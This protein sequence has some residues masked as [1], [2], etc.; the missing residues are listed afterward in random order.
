MINPLK[1]TDEVRDAYLRY[2]LTTFEVSNLELRQAFQ[3]ELHTNSGYTKGPYLEATPPFRKGRSL[4]QLVIGGQFSRAWLD[5]PSI[6]LDRSLYAHQDRAIDKILHGRNIIV[7]T[8]TGSGKTEA[9]LYPIVDALMREHEAGTLTP[10]VRALL[11][12][13]MNALVNDQLKR[14]R[15]LLCEMSYISFGRF[16]GETK[17]T[18][19]EALAEYPTPPPPG[20]RISREA[21]RRDP[22]HILITNYAMLEYLLQRPADTP[23]FD[24]KHAGHWRFLVLDEVHTYNG[25]SGAEVGMLVRR[26]KDRLGIAHL[27]AIGTSATMGSGEKDFPKV[28]EFATQLFSEP[29]DWIQEDKDQQDVVGADRLSLSE[30]PT[31]WGRLR[32]KAYELLLE[33]ATSGTEPTHYDLSGMGIPQK[34]LDVLER[35]WERGGGQRWVYDLLRGDENIRELSAALTTSKPLLELIELF[36]RTRDFDANGFLAMVNLAV[37]AKPSEQDQSLIP[38]RYHLFVRATE[39]VFVGLY[40]KSKIFLTRHE[41]RRVGSA[42]YPVFELGYCRRCGGTY[43]VGTID[44]AHKLKPYA[45]YR[46]Q[47]DIQIQQSPDY[48]GLT[49]GDEEGVDDDTEGE[50]P[51]H[52]ESLQLCQRCGWIGLTTVVPPSNC[53]A[54]DVHDLIPVYKSPVSP[55]G[56]HRCIHCGAGKGRGPSRFIT[57]QDA[58]AAV[59]ATAVYSSL[60]PESP[61]A[62]IRAED[63]GKL[64]IFSD[65]RQ[66]AAFFAPYLETSYQRIV[67]RR[68]IWEA[69]TQEDSLALGNP[70]LADVHDRLITLSDKYGMMA[71]QSGLSPAQKSAQ[72]WEV[73]LR[74]LVSGSDI[75]LEGVGMVAIEPIIDAKWSPPELAHWSDTDRVWDLLT[76]LWNDFRAHGAFTLPNQV[77]PASILPYEALDMPGFSRSTRSS[78]SMPWLPKE[79]YRNGRLDYLAR[80]GVKLGWPSDVAG[81]WAADLLNDAFTFFTDAS[82]P[83]AQNNCFGAAG[84]NGVVFKAK[85]ERWTIR[86]LGLHE[87]FRCNACGRIFVRNIHGVCPA[88]KC[89]GILEHADSNRLEENHYYQLYS[90]INPIPMKSREHTAQINNFDAQRL[91]EQFARGEVSV[92][93]CSTTFEL[94]V[95][96][97]ELEAVFMRNVPPE[98]ANYVQRAGRAGRRTSTAAIA[99]TFA[100]RRSHDIAQFNSPERYVNGHVAP[101]RVVLSNEKIARRHLH[102]I[103]TSWYFR[104]HPETYGSMQKFLNGDGEDWD[105]NLKQLRMELNPVPLDLEGSISRVIPQEL[106]EELEVSTNGWVEQFVGPKGV[107]TQ[108]VEVLHETIAEIRDLQDRRYH[109]GRRVDAYGKIIKTL[110]AEPSLSFFPSHNVL[111]KYGFPVDVVPLRIIHGSEEASRLEL[112]RDLGLAIW[113]YAPGNSVVAGGLLWKSRALVQRP[114]MTWKTHQ[115]AICRE[116]GYFA[117]SKT[118]L[119]LDSE[120]CEGCG[121]QLTKKANM[122]IPQ[123]GFTT[124]IGD[125]PAPPGSQ[126]P[127]RV[128]GRRV[129]FSAFGEHGSPERERQ[130]LR[131]GTGIEWAYSKSG[132]FTVIN[133]G[134]FGRGY[135]ICNLCGWAEPWRGMEKVSERPTHDKPF[136]IPCPGT[137]FYRASLGHQFFTDVVLLTFPNLRENDVSFWHSLLYGL[138]EGAI[139]GLSITRRDVGATL[140]WTGSK[141]N[142]T[143]VFYDDVPGGAGHVKHMTRN[144]E[145]VFD[146]ALSRVSGS[147]GCGPETS[148]YGCL[149]SYDNQLFHDSLVRGRAETFLKQLSAS[150]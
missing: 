134:Q 90:T 99:V 135:R 130:L 98:P 93:S 139:G 112:T 80:L 24:G 16:T 122:L 44:D 100:Q 26:L 127:E 78:R 62:H 96:A 59:V 56:Y 40:P 60:Q 51:T 124:S 22:P 92:L 94:G 84:K 2:L 132:R 85:Y 129:F 136:G 76:V 91:Q 145:R 148:C 67:W 97:G 64:L 104:R 57:G 1:L 32:P 47:D 131:D 121:G 21:L 107:L 69:L 101:P 125:K 68:L 12:Y 108:S 109:E 9:F 55:Q 52:L 30:F 103:V 6:P 45:P 133:H 43:I 114:G 72:V 3:E 54:E 120:V 42:E 65:S 110:L 79:G 48:F 33:V 86:P 41:T 138:L 144:W 46:I 137:S 89:S 111:P 36:R 66:D 8:G 128:G 29:F 5:V 39:G 14:L 140:Y 49:S 149:R 147:C 63:I 81:D 106:H 82:H 119:A 23:F 150:G 53:H 74:E 95:D 13:P 25:A 11:L 28:V 105:D 19:A 20:E 87:A 71:L 15:E 143:L 142:P 75:G 88:W 18:D 116:C 7:S 31:P 102:A 27:Q 83:W 70:W 38:A 141:A 17:E 118:G 10:G 61:A 126:R 77:L 115:Y 4:R 58:A 50:L 35:E 117:I 73:L 146:E 37:W 123:F 113:E 34:H